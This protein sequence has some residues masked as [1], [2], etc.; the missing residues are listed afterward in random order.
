MGY[1]LAVL[2]LFAP[3]CRELHDAR[4][5][6][7]ASGDIGYENTKVAVIECAG[8]RSLVF[9]RREHA[10]GA[11]NELHRVKVTSPLANQTWFFDGATCVM[12]GAKGDALLMNHAVLAHAKAATGEVST[13][14][15]S[16]SWHVDL[17][18]N[19]WVKDDV[20]KMTCYGD[21]P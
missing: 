12:K 4:P 14:K 11:W 7:S 10:D 2:L 5:R 1:A 8:E 19:K 15:P 16:E 18:K 6:F 9:S 20:K 3:E 17:G 13:F 21:E